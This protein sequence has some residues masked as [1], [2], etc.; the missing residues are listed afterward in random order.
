MDEE[1]LLGEKRQFDRVSFDLNVVLDGSDG[2]IEADSVDISENGFRLISN[3]M[4]SPNSRYNLVFSLNEEVKDIHCVASLMWTN[5]MPN[6]KYLS[7]F[8][9]SNV[10]QDDRLKIRKFIQGSKK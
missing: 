5:Q 7:G 4:F 9:F 3:K 8:V 6:G 1:S 10:S 2:K